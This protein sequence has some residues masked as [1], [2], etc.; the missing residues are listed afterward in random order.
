MIDYIIIAIIAFS[1]II[2]LL[3]GFI[4]EVMSVAS[5]VVAFFVANHFYPYLANYLTQIE[6]LYLRNGTAIAILFVATL[7]VGGIVNHILGELVDKTGL[8]GTDRV[9]GACFG[10]I[11]GVL[12]VAALLFFMDTFT[13]FSQTVWWKESKLI[14]HFGFIVEWFFQ[15]LQ[16]TSSFINSTLNK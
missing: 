8:T 9:L 6:S 5:W 15:Q 1:I 10:L 4:R 2:S 12:I 16:A 3:R 7:I 13:N 11:R 14:P